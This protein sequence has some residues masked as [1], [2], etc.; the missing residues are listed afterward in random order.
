MAGCKRSSRPL[1][2]IILALKRIREGYLDGR[3]EVTTNDEIGYTGDVINE[4]AAGL[5]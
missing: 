1:N 5:K 3:V 4:M 2:G